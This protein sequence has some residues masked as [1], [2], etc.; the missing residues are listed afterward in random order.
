MLHWSASSSS[1]IKHCILQAKKQR[2]RLRSCKDGL[3]ADLPNFG[4][5]SIVLR[6]FV[7][8]KLYMILESEED[9]QPCCFLD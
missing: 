2:R 9:S 1:S 4:V 5:A 8:T 7:F 6:P 3:V